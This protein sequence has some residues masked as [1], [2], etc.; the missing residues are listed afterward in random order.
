MDILVK[1]VDM[2]TDGKKIIS[3]TSLSTSNS[4]RS[5]WWPRRLRNCI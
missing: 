3:M 2:D 4:T 5:Y 1:T